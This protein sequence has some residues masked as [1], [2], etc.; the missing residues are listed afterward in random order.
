MNRA[1]HYQHIP[2]TSC[3]SYKANTKLPHLLQPTFE[4][5]KFHGA[6]CF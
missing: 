2:E 1:V 4:G 5:K 6:E 3:L